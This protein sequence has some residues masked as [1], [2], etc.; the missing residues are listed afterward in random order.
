MDPHRPRHEAAIAAVRAAVQVVHEAAA[1]NW[2]PGP[3]GAPRPFNHREREGLLA[4]SAAW[5]EYV[6][7]SRARWGDETLYLDEDVDPGPPSVDPA[8]D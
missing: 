5:R 7:A 2:Q 3:G 1:H 6:A 4:L 8:A